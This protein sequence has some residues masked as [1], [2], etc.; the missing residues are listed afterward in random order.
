MI[1]KGELCLPTTYIVQGTVMFSVV[2]AGG[3]GYPLTHCGRQEG[4]PPP[5]LTG[6]KDQW[7]GASRK[8]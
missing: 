8:D 7:D 3:G 2:S 6:G 5:L 1:N 4:D